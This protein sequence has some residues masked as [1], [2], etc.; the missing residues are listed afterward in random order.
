MSSESTIT[1]DNGRIWDATGSGTIEHGRLTIEGALISKVAP[2]EHIED[3]EAKPSNTIDVSG[4]TVMPGLID[5]HGHFSLYSST[6]YP[7]RLHEKFAAYSRSSEFRM[8]YAAKRLRNTLKAGVT[9]VRDMAGMST[10]AMSALRDG[11]N[12]GLIEG[13]RLVVAGVTATTN[14]HLH[15]VMDYGGRASGF[16]LADGPWEMRKL[17][18]QHFFDGADLLKV[19]VSGGVGTGRPWNERMDRRLITREELDAIIDEGRAYGRPVASHAYTAESAR[20]AVDAGTSSLEHSVDIDDDTLAGM[21]EQ[22]IALVPTL[23]LHSEANIERA[24]RMGTP[25]WAIEK[26]KSVQQGCYDTFQRA[27]AAGVRIACGTDVA[28]ESGDGRTPEE[29]ELYVQLGMS[30]EEAL[31]SATRVAAEVV[32]R[33]HQLGTLEAGKLADVIVVKGNPLEDITAL[34]KP[35]E[36]ILLVIQ[37]GKIVVDRRSHV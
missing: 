29:L 30:T 28:Y 10:I 37:G 8:L 1:L 33:S 25:S 4:Y 21:V 16:Y 20:I 24:S 7:T 15:P 5:A 31:L 27:H 34:Q 13:A 6:D 23:L 19:D 2:K 18:R 12:E 35:E 36:N 17:A 14:S 26:I 11:V 9:T 22:G 3:Q 32:Q